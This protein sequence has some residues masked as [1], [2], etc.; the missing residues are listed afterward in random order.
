MTRLTEVHPWA[1]DA[2]DVTVI[3]VCYNHEK[4]VTACLESIAAQTYTN[5]ECLVFD[6]A[7]T[8]GSAQAIHAW[9]NESGREWTFVCHQHN[10]G[11]ITTLNE[12]LRAARGRFMCLI[13]ADDIMAPRRLADQVPV[14]ATDSAVGFVYS[15]ADVIDEYG[16]LTGQTWQ[17]LHHVSGM[18][19]AGDIFDRILEHHFVPAMTM[20][21]RTD[22]LREA[23][24]FAE[25]LYHEDWD[26]ALKL[27]YSRHVAFSPYHAAFYRV[28]P[29]SLSK[30]MPDWQ[31]DVTTLLLMRRWMGQGRRSDAIAR[32]R[33]FAS[34]YSLW[35]MHSERRWWAL[36]LAV[37]SSRHPTALVIPLLATLRLPLG[38]LVRMRR[39]ALSALAGSSL[40]LGQSRRPRD[41]G[42]GRRR[43]KLGPRI[44]TPPR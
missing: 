13:A 14:L 34:T 17:D 26:L 21:F 3:V 25:E 35:T 23:G 22:H 44:P 24:G 41:A 4:Y 19:P 43:K 11:L 42:A 16:E 15:D 27:A 39:A 28:T 12:A 33:I 36:S 29:G 1:A 18:R 10:R 38:S 9:L 7:S 20:L 32:R 37:R 6:D 31:E 40:P 8:D 2:P 30:T 5:Y